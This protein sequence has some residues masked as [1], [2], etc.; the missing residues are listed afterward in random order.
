[1]AAILADDIFNCIFLNANDGI[2]IQIL[3]EFV[4]RDLINNIPIRRQA[5]IQTNVYSIHW[6]IYAALRGDKLS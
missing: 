3:L 1:M 5:I 6:H 2:P 4:A